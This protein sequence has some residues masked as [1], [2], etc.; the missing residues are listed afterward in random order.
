MSI[1]V[2]VYF[3]YQTM[4]TIDICIMWS[5]HDHILILYYINQNYWDFYGLYAHLMLVQ[6]RRLYL[7]LESSICL[8][9]RGHFMYRRNAIVFVKGQTLFVYVIASLRAFLPIEIHCYVICITV[10][11]LLLFIYDHDCSFH[12]FIY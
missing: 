2:Y 6:S 12:M 4:N 8:Q 7:E 1:Y 11:E 10:M 5:I 3:G 9:S